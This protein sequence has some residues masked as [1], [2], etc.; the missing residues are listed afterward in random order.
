MLATFED[1]TLWIAGT[2]T[3]NVAA[4][5]STVFMGSQ[6]TEFDKT[7][8][9]GTTATI[10][11]T[12]KVA[13]S[14]SAFWQSPRLVK[15][16]L[17]HADFTNVSKIT[18][19]LVYRHDSSAAPDRYD[20]YEIASGA[21][22]GGQWNTLSVDLTTPDAQSGTP[23]TAADRDRLQALAVICTMGASGNT[24]SNLIV[25]AAEITSPGNLPKL[26]VIVFD[27]TRI[28]VPPFKRWLQELQVSSQVNIAEQAA[29]RLILT[30]KAGVSFGW[31]QIRHTYHGSDS[32]LRGLE[33]SL[34]YFAQYAVANNGWAIARRSDRV[35]DTTLTSAVAAGALSIPVASVTDI[36]NLHSDVTELRIGPNDSRQYDWVGVVSRSSSTLYLDRPLRYAH[37]SAV[38]V[39]SLEFFP[40]CAYT[41]TGW[42]LT[43]TPDEVRFSMSALETA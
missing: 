36:T 8:T 9:S 1:E 32:A 24:I 18:L 10:T 21:L 17:H 41:G 20:D 12:L 43:P 13:M 35:I 28:L 26:G 30:V 5:A 34:G 7:G 19:R 38:A 4:Q 14:V 33:D 16:R 23:P 31:D 25:D 2:D 39:R 29:E 22:T 11:K 37:E 6:A 40:S 27:S 15:L 3:A 42:P